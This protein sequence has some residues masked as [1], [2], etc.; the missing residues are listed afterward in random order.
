MW[1][2]VAQVLESD[3]TNFTL[4]SYYHLST[5]ERAYADETMKVKYSLLALEHKSFLKVLTI[6]LLLTLLDLSIISTPFKAH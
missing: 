1:N 2:M 6:T 3:D 4:M 5:R